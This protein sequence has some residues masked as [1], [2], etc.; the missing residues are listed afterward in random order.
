[1][2]REVYESS[3]GGEHLLVEAGTGTGKSLGYLIPSIY[4]S[5]QTDEKVVISTN[6]IN[7]QDQI[8]YRDIPLLQELFP[9]PFRAAVLKG[10]SHYLCLRK[11][12]FK[13]NAAEFEN[14]NEDP[15]TAAQMVVWLG[16]TESGDEEELHLTGKGR[17]FWRTV[18]SD[19]ESCLNRACPWF[20]RC[21]YHRAKHEPNMPN[22][23]HTNH[24]MLFTDIK[25]EHRLL[26]TYRIWWSM[27]R[28]NLKKPQAS[29]LV[30]NQLL[31]P[32]QA[33]SRTVQGLITTGSCPGLFSGSGAIIRRDRR[34][35]SPKGSN[36][37]CPESLRQRKG[38]T[39]WR[40]GCLRSRSQKR[41]SGTKRGRADRAAHQARQPS[42]RLGR[43]GGR[44][45]QSARRTRRADPTAGTGCK[46]SEGAARRSGG[47][48]N[49][50]RFRRRAER[51]GA[52]AG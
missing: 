13:M 27:R 52:N 5:L 26:P 34:R 28:I 24:A 33:P 40:T 8:R 32:V 17:D 16:E 31:W 22:R 20:K 23:D 25:A 41:R 37:A 45:R 10:R 38:G 11:F 51:L 39:G 47:A 46:R 6:T 36:P 43:G 15:I 3:T 1:M 7:L 44:R 29:I 2:I 9:V 4:Y 42:G 14:P 35:K 21:Y 49:A 50:H 18:E 12:D 30:S 48:R 19:S